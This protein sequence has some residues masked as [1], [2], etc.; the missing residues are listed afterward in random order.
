MVLL[1][2]NQSVETKTYVKSV[3]SSVIKTKKV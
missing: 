2:Y 1:V 3:S